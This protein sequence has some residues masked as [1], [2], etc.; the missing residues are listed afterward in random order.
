MR[1]LLEYTGMRGIQLQSEFHTI[2]DID[3][4]NTKMSK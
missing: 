4:N 3:I 2:L 1:F